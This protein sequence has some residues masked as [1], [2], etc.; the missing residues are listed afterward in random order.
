MSLASP[1]ALAWLAI[2]V[3]IVILYVL[4]IRLRR[5]PISSIMLWN[6]IFDEKSPR[7]I[8]QRLRHLISLLLQLAFLIF[9]ALALADPFW[10]WQARD[11]RRIALVIDTSASMSAVDRA[12]FASA[13]SSQP[14]TGPATEPATGGA[15][16]S[17]RPRL[18]EAKRLARQAIDALRDRDT[19]A[20]IAAG[21]QPRVVCGLT[22]HHRTLGDALESIGSTDGPT[23]VAEAVE[24]AQRVLADEKNRSI[25]I[26]SDGG[27]ETAGDL[28]R[29]IV[30]KPRSRAAAP[31]I[32]TTSAPASAAAE[33]ASKVDAESETP[34]VEF[35]RVG[36][37][38]AN[39]GV[40]R[41]QVRRSL[42]DPLGYEILADVTN[43]S[44]APAECRFEIELDD[45]ILDVFPLKLEPGQTWSQVIRKASGDG[46]RLVAKLAPPRG[47]DAGASERAAEY[48]DA[49]ASDNRAYAVLPKRR[50][51]NVILVT[52]GNLFLRGV[53]EANPLV[54][55]TVTREAPAAVGPEDIVIYHKRG[56]ET[57][58]VGNTIIIDPEA[59]T[60]LFGVGDPLASP[61][62]A[63]QDGESPLMAHV[64]L[65]NVIMPRARKLTPAG[66][67]AKGE[68]PA[69]TT[70]A[71]VG[72]V[73][74]R[75]LAEA[76]NGE[77]VYFVAESPG[78]RVLV[79]S[80][81]IEQGDLPLR[82]AFPILITNAL[83]WFAD[84][85]GEL[86]EALST[87]AVGEIELP[88]VLREAAA[89]ELISPSGVARPVLRREDRVIVGPLEE[90][91]FW[92]VRPSAAVAS[93]PAGLSTATRPG[94]VEALLI[95][96]NLNDRGESNL[97]VPP[98]LPT[99]DSALR[100][101]FGG[102]PLWFYLVALAC[103]LSAVEWGL[104]QRRKVG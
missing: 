55:L 85:K 74:S 95:A 16:V 22:G 102:Q 38:T 79:L 4:K 19:M 52:A 91:G 17:D 64:R 65:D 57:V 40:T 94:E 9:L 29:G 45:E 36:G 72:A 20:V 41:F 28:A 25:V 13:A 8:W 24:L 37:W 34:K 80:A 10:S 47:R 61:L 12:E 48:I 82:T 69:A 49:L 32:I 70:P 23:R 39:V 51:Q 75:V 84:A 11:A 88:A 67:A 50:P 60:D 101:A 97:R 27:F 86:N 99:S 54:N 103:L 93:A 100:A 63:K 76:I 81:D 59:S 15:F 92:T 104:Y 21:S 56:P 46:G 26:V 68:R 3:P 35:V 18:K 73:K 83:A 14:A 62:V 42:G 90:V 30:P 43:Q 7:S 6:E 78:R 44:D 66:L 87:G 58:P 1:L 53:F 96:C 31:A 2:A 98:D 71:S 33:S 5:V 89:L 77:P